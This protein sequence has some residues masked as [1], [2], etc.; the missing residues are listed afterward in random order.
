MR[1]EEEIERW[2]GLGRRPGASR[3]APLCDTGN[4]HTHLV[5]A[6]FVGRVTVGHDAVGAHDDRPNALLL[7]KKGNHRVGN[8]G[9][10]DLL[11]DKLVRGESR[12][13]YVVGVVYHGHQDV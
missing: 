3:S 5:G 7:H 8:Q 11:G 2:L 12:T 9:P 10:G 4:P 13:L 6:Y 1:A